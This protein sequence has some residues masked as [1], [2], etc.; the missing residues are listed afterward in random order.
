MTS[1]GDLSRDTRR[2]RILVFVIGGLALIGTGIALFDLGA[3]FKEPDVRIAT[4]PVPWIAPIFLCVA[5]I[6]VGLVGLI[7]IV[8]GPRK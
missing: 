7:T 1:E 3:T 6:V 8:R 2:R 5:G 4:V